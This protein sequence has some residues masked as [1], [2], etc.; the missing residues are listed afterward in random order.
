MQIRAQRSELIRICRAVAKA[1]KVPVKESLCIVERKSSGVRH[2]PVTL[3]V[4]ALK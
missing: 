2:R 3:M 1:R 4:N